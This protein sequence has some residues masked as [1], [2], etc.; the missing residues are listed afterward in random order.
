[1]GEPKR[2]DDQKQALQG[3]LRQTLPSKLPLG[4]LTT[5]ARDV[6]PPRP[7]TAVKI[8]ETT[9]LGMCYPFLPWHDCCYNHKNWHD[10]SP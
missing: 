1:M 6:A 4:H 7:Q 10:F 2:L 3:G 8:E 9:A 5:G